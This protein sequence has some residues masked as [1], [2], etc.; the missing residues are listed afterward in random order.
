MSLNDILEWQAVIALRG[1]LIF[2]L[3]P[4]LISIEAIS[5]RTEHLALDEAAI[6]RDNARAAFEFELTRVFTRPDLLSLSSCAADIS[7]YE[8]KLSE[9]LR[10]L[11]SLAWSAPI[12]EHGERFQHIFGNTSPLYKNLW[13]LLDYL[14]AIR[15]PFNLIQG[16]FGPAF[17]VPQDKDLST[18]LKVV[19]DVNILLDRLSTSIT[20]QTPISLRNEDWSTPTLV[21]RNEIIRE[22]ASTAF[23]SVFSHLGGCTTSHSA[24]LYL[25]S[26]HSDDEVPRRQPLLDMF[27]SS[28]PK[29]NVWRD[30][31]CRYPE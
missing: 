7:R 31:Q 6:L 20:T 10:L 12:Q 5:S 30:I 14:E 26:Q 18:H 25:R 23:E 13:R 3:I 1:Y 29:E 27:I 4:G 16:R 22:Y 21:E 17:R 19:E 11:D 2:T 8:P 15:Q 28:C 24:M 9:F